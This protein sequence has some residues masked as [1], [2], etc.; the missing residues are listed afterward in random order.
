MTQK[1]LSALSL[2]AIESQLVMGID[3]ED[4]INN[5]AHTK[6]RKKTF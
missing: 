5:F 1:R 4:L 2:M 6:S 3:F